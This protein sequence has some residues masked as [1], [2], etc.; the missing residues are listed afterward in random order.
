[1]GVH[2][3]TPVAELKET[4]RDAQLLQVSVI[5]LA[6]MSESVALTENVTG[7]SSFTVWLLGTDRVGGRFTSLTVII[8][9][10][11]LNP[12]RSLVAVKLKE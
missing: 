3:N 12:P 5:M 6:G 8:T 11:E 10:F 4:P 2:E 1:V 9:V 7:V